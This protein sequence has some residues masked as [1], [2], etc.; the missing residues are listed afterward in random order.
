MVLRAQDSGTG[1][2]G[3]MWSGKAFW[4]S[5]PFHGSCTV[6]GLG[7]ESLGGWGGPS[8]PQLLVYF[9]LGHLVRT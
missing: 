6:G 2:E 5:W 3:W 9:M 4:N 8:P 1:C 7:L